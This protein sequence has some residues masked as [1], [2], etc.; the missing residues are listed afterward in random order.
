FIKKYQSK[1][2]S[3]V[4]CTDISKDGMLEGPSFNLY[5][6][7]LQETP[8]IKLIASGGVSTFDEIPILAEMNCEGVI[9]GKA[10]YEN[11]ISLN[12][13]ETYILNS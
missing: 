11:R 9:I 7:I 3:Y 10:I 1:G 2:I 5:E 12:Q 4:I 13:L 6:K 8:T